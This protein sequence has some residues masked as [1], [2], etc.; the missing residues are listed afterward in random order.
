MAAIR[1]GRR[2]H[3]GGPDADARRRLAVDAG[4]LA[5]L[6]GLALAFVLAAPT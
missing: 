6:V 2:S 1:R 4:M 5:F 3:P